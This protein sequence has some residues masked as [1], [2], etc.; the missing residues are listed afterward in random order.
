MERWTVEVGDAVV[1]D[2]LD[3]RHARK[4]YDDYVRASTGTVGAH[5]GKPVTCAVPTS[6]SGPTPRTRGPCACCGSYLPDVQY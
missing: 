3:A 5:V 1:T 2:T 6:W 4:A